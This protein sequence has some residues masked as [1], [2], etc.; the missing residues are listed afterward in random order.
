M[1]SDDENTNMVVGGLG[2]SVI[3][4]DNGAIEARALGG[5]LIAY[6]MEAP[7]GGGVFV[8]AYKYDGENGDIGTYDLVRLD[9]GTLEVTARRPLD[10]W[11]KV[12]IV[13]SRESP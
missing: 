3:N 12:F 13:P 10:A 2:L 9:A 6:F 8:T 4:L 1:S 5:F 7:D 11:V